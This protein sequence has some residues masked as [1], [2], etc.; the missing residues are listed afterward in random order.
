MNYKKVPHTED[1]P[2]GTTFSEWWRGHFS[3]L[4]VGLPEG[5]WGARRARLRRLL[6]QAFEERREEQE[7][8]C[9]NLLFVPSTLAPPSE[10]E[11]SQYRPEPEGDE[12]PFIYTCGKCGA[13]MPG[14]NVTNHVCP[15]AKGS[16]APPWH[17]AKPVK[18]E[19]RVADPP[20]DAA[21]MWESTPGMPYVSDK[22]ARQR[23]QRDTHQPL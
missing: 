10:F 12:G 14:E 11:K 6:E 9:S 5:H 15:E 8:R 13:R 2:A 16:G 4:N 21:P 19:D 23:L 7:Q 1:D 20:S 3:L 22:E 18:E 17:P